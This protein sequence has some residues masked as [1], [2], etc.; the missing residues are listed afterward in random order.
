M[1]NLRYISLFIMLVTGSVWCYAQQNADFVAAYN[2]VKKG[3]IDSARIYI[4]KASKDSITRKDPQYWYVRGFVYKELYKKYEAATKKSVYRDTA[5]NDLLKS[6]KIDSTADN[7][8]SNYTTL[9]YISGTYYNDATDLMDSLHYVT[10]KS[11]YAK[12][13]YLK[14]LSDPTAN[15]T[16][17]EI[18]FNLKLGEV[19]SYLFFHANNAKIKS[20]Y[21]DSSKGAYNAVLAINPNE[22]SANYNLAI[23]Y[24][25][26]AV[27]IINETSYD[28]DISKLNAAQDTSVHL[29]MQSLPFMQKTYQLDP[30]KKDAVKGLEGIYYLL[31]DTQKFQEYE[32]KLK[33]LEGGK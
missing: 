23:L 16:Q 4:D 19:Y 27:Y 10:A 20:H 31:H 24:Y 15:L 22:V 12:A 30:Q 29:A 2:C 6:V 3:S 9:K 33:A 14:K 7:K 21:L 26:Q 1:K 18:Q 17:L 11:Y 28:D 5:A 25:N 32:D 8:Q 13:M